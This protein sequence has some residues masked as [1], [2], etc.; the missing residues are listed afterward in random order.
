MNIQIS[1]MNLFTCF[2]DIFDIFLEEAEN[3]EILFTAL[4][5]KRK[6]RT[7]ALTTVGATAGA[8]GITALIIKML[9]SRNLTRKAV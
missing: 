6:L 3:A 4:A 2:D 9:K 1:V 8:I 7:A 5:K